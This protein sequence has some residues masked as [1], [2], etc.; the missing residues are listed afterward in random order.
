MPIQ[1]C[2][3]MLFKWKSPGLSA[4]LT[5]F[6]TANTPESYAVWA[7]R[8]KSLPA[9]PPSLV[10]M[11]ETL[12]PWNLSA[13]GILPGGSLVLTP[14]RKKPQ[15]THILFKVPYNTY[16]L[17]SITI[18]RIPFSLCMKPLEVFFGNFV[19]KVLSVINIHSS[20]HRWKINRMWFNT[21]GV[22]LFCLFPKMQSRSVWLR[23]ER[24]FP[25][26]TWCLQ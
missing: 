16:H 19:W 15:I 9:T 23:D 13:T 6:P 20:L 10:Q 22:F 11:G 7:K 26:K 21:S 25:R 18:K 5:V 3:K 17:S 12:A 24:S 2:L 4:S 1:H 8:A 14:G